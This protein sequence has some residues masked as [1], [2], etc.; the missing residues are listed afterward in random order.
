VH[1]ALLAHTASSGT[2]T[3]TKYKMPGTISLHVWP[4]L[5]QVINQL[6]EVFESFVLSSSL[7]LG[8]VPLCEPINLNFKPLGVSS[9]MG[10]F[11]SCGQR[12]RGQP[13]EHDLS[14]GVQGVGVSAQQPGGCARHAG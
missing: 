13:R 5:T 3:A 8:S 14:G 4:C 11:E 10:H 6:I 7:F 9:S 2:D 1:T 12:T